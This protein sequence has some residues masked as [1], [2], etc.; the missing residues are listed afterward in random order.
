MY[1]SECANGGIYLSNKPLN[2][3]QYSTVA[4]VKCIKTKAKKI[5]KSG[6]F[7]G[8]IGITTKGEILKI[9]KVKL[10]EGYERSNIREGSIPFKKA[11]SSK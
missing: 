3:N 2:Q 1:V 8:A 5:T 10:R 11:K 7:P 9:V 6:I 4:T